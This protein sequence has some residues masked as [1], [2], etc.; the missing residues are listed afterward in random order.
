MDLDPSRE[1]GLACG[2]IC[3]ECGRDLVAHLGKVKAAHFQHATDDVICDPQPMTLLHAFARDYIARRQHLWLPGL[4]EDFSDDRWGSTWRERFETLD[5][6]AAIRDGATEAQQGSFVPDVLL[7]LEG[8]R[9][10][11][12]EVKYSHAV[13]EEKSFK[14]RTHRLDCLEFDVSDLAPS[15]ATTALLEQVLL[16]RARWK[17]IWNAERD[18]AWFSF[19]ARVDWQGGTWRVDRSRIGQADM[20]MPRASDKLRIAQARLGWAKSAYDS[21]RQRSPRPSREE[22]AQWLGTY[23]TAKQGTEDRFAIFCAAAG[24]EPTSLPVNFMQKINDGFQKHVYAWQLGIFVT[25]GFRQEWFSSADVAAWVKAA[26]PECA[27]R[28]PDWKNRNG[29]T[30]DGVAAHT[31][32]LLLESQGLLLSDGHRELERRLFRAKFRS[33]Q[34]FHHDLPRLRA[35]SA[36]ARI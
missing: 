14:F 26:M 15:L 20:Y 31:Y 4:V 6:N 33:R 13:D 27:A 19:L 28:Q 1:R 25:F 17:W 32:L 11:A 2:C 8:E 10:L 5:T 36:V 18:R 22:T 3:V 30:R 23:A 24:L 7:T 9:K 16:E 21:F 29:F 35:A 12:I 34:E